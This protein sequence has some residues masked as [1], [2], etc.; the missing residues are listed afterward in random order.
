VL[1]SN[2]PYGMTSNR[3]NQHN[4]ISM[5]FLLAA[6]QSG[7]LKLAAKVA[8]SVKKDL[9][10]QMRYYNSLGESQPNEQLAV[11]AQM[12]EQQKGGN[13]TEKQGEF[14]NDILSSYQMLMQLDQWSKQFGGS[15]SPSKADNQPK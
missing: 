6:Y 2:F 9:E 10:Q 1:E 7:D 15:G 13:L 5:S 14:T 12:A 8:A 3:G 11:N 4:K